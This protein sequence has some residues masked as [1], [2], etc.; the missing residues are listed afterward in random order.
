MS[1]KIACCKKETRLAGRQEK[2]GSGIFIP[3]PGT[4]TM[5][6][7]ELLSIMPRIRGQR[8]RDRS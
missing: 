1:A 8:L 4:S 7:K 3:E 6:D 2:S 5:E